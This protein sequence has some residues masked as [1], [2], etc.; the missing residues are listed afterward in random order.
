MMVAI[1]AITAAGGQYVPIDPSA[2]R[3]R[4]EYM[5]ATASVSLV[6]VRAG[7]EVPD[8]LGGLPAGVRLVGLDASGDIDLSTRAIVDAERAGALRASN[9]AYTLFTSGSTGRPKGVTV[10]HEAIVNRLAWM[11]AAYPMTSEDRVLQK[12][13]TTFDVSVWELYWPL[14][15][16]VPLVIAEP[17]RH[18]DPDTWRS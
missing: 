9:A 2:P 5:V 8:A 17:E 18:G 14:I 4:A 1:H 6:L 11:D 3:E 7:T 13:P 10:S 16:G 15:A 12:T